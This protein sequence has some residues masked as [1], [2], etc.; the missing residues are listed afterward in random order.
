VKSK[1]KQEVLFENPPAWVDM[2]QGMPEFRQEDLKPWKSLNVHFRNEQD[3]Q[4]FLRLLGQKRHPASSQNSLWYPEAE[5]G[6]Y[7][8]KRIAS[9]Y[10][11]LP[12]YPIFIPSKGRMNTRKTM[13]SF[14]RI[15]VP[16]SVVVEPQEYDAYATVIDPER[17]I[18]TPHS[19]QGLVVTRN[20]IWDYAA[21]LGTPRYWTFDD[22]ISGFYRLNQNLKVP[23]CD[24]TMF[25]AIEEFADRYENVP[26]AGCNYF[27]FADRKTTLPPITLNTRVYS[28]MLIQTDSVDVG[29]KPFRNEGF[30]NDDTDLCIRVLKDGQ[31]VVLF[32]AFL[33]DKEDTMSVKGGMTPHYQE[34]G[35]YKMAKELADKHPDCVTIT[36]KWGRPQHQVNYSAF[37]KNKLKLKPGIVIPEGVDDYGMSL[38]I[39]EEAK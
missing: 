4:A 13:K 29:G 5:L 24:G 34:D 19:N 30:Y 6:I 9:E 16:Y 23:V 3:Y 22:N 38:K 10:P 7:R 18:V 27:M 14:D 26:I 36:E 33:I 11:K 25:Y 17:L 39:L 2:W 12:R 35:R 28:N 1:D 8:D 21:K 31:C 32:N 20:W 15:N 37:R